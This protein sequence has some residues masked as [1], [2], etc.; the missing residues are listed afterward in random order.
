MLGGIRR[1]LDLRNAVLKG[2]MSLN[3]TTALHAPSSDSSRFGV[4]PNTSGGLQAG[5]WQID[6]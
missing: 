3:P 2:T 6:F 1:K 5:C 4:K